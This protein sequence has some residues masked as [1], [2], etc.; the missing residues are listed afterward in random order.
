VRKLRDSGAR[1]TELPVTHYARAYGT[2][3]FFK[4]ARIA[5][6]LNGFARWYLRL[7][8]LREQKR[9][10]KRLQRERLLVRPEA[11]TSKTD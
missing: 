4:P 8:L 7:V 6:A 10:V 3:Q 5:R 11:S 9:R 2:S 1:M